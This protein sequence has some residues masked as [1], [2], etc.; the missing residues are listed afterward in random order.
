MTSYAPELVPSSNQPGKGK[1]DTT[2]ENIVLSPAQIGGT[3]YS[4]CWK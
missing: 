1:Q 3:G 2:H 4:Y